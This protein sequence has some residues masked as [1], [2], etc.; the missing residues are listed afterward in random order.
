M[1]EMVCPSTVFHPNQYTDLSGCELSNQAASKNR[2]VRNRSTRLRQKRSAPAEEQ[3]SSSTT[4]LL[5]IISGASSDE[6]E[7]YSV[8]RRDLSGVK[9]ERY[10][11]NR[12]NSD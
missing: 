7:R 12:S 6:I 8:A 5:S 10:K 2:K 9:L 11:H 1:D 3:P 4:L